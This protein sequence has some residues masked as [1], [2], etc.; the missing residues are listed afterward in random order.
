MSSHSLLALTDQN[1]LYFVAYFLPMFWWGHSFIRL[2]HAPTVTVNVYGNKADHRYGGELWTFHSNSFHELVLRRQ[3]KQNPSYQF[4]F[5]QKKNHCFVEW[6]LQIAYR[7]QAL[8]LEHDT[9]R[10]MSLS[11]TYDTAS[12]LTD[13]SKTSKVDHFTA[14]F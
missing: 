13:V 4:H 6:L 2:K 5:S 12:P 9:I 11:F 7:Q 1:R 3:R 10:V 14:I 8:L